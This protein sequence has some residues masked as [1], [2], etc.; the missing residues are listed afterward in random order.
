MAGHLAVLSDQLELGELELVKT[1]VHIRGP[2]APSTSSR[3]PG[4]CSG[5]NDMGQAMGSS[6]VLGQTG[7]SRRGLVGHEENPNGATGGKDG[8]LVLRCAT[9]TGRP[10][11]CGYKTMRAHLGCSG[12]GTKEVPKGCRWLVIIF[13]PRSTNL[14]GLD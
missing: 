3:R 5:T 9:A 12:C 6:L 14:Q 2:V 13:L 10:T 1:E 4:P 8:G 11:G 7:G